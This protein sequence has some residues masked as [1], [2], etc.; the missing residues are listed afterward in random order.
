MEPLKRCLSRRTAVAGALTAY[1][2]VHLASSDAKTS[3]IM[4]SYTCLSF[5]IPISPCSFVWSMLQAPGLVGVAL[6]GSA[7]AVEAAPSVANATTS[8][9]VVISLLYIS[10]L[11]RSSLLGAAFRGCACRNDVRDAARREQVDDVK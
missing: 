1:R 3:G 10:F 6:F 8:E 11:L 4:M 9:I 7:V 5:I 2:G